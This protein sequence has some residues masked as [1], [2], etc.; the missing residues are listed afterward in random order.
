MKELDVPTVVLSDS[1]PERGEPNVVLS[2]EGMMCQKN[3]GSTVQTALSNVPNVTK[4]LVSFAK[5]EAQIWGNVSPSILI[6][7]VESVGFDAA[8][9]KVAS[10]STRTDKTE[11]K[12]ANGLNSEP[13]VVLSIE[14]MMCQKN[15]GST[16]QAALSN[17]PNVTKAVVSFAKKEAQIWGN[18]TSS[19]LVSA[20]ESVGFD[21]AVSTGTTAS[22]SSVSSPSKKSKSTV[23]ENDRTKTSSLNLDKGK[24]HREFTIEGRSVLEM[25]VGGMSCTSCVNAVESGLMQVKG[26]VSVRVALLAEKAEIVFDNSVVAE[27][28][29]VA[30]TVALGYSACILNTRKMGDGGAK[31]EMMF[32]VTGMSCANCAIKLERTLKGRPGVVEIGVSAVTNKAR[33]VVDGDIPNALGPRDVTEL[34]EGIGFGCDLISGAGRSSGDS[35]SDGMEDMWAWARLLFFAAVLGLPVLILH[36]SMTYN[37][38]IK[39]YYMRPGACDGNVSKGQVIMAILNIPMQFGV[40]YRFYKSAFIGLMH[41]NYGM[42]LLVVTGTSITFVYSFV[43]LSMACIVGEPTTH[44]F[45]EASGNTPYEHALEHIL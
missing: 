29:I 17:V 19:I 14:G 30:A 26:V 41:K 34:I 4:A 24:A 21:A 1:E 16:V 3:C 10:S 37:T 27:G 35:Q 20:V 12:D 15:C 38:R 7:A 39:M 32:K 40:G 2:I 9:M 36:M 23:I 33:V 6:S 22:S 42:D 44:I 8:V 45:F 28:T 18:V 31:K 11:A 5:K 25:K 13:N 43:Q